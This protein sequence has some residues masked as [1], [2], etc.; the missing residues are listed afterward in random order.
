MKAKTWFNIG[1]TILTF[2]IGLAVLIFL[3][4]QE[5]P[6][7]VENNIVAF[8][9]LPII[10]FVCISLA[11]FTLYS[12]RWQIILNSHLP[13]EK[14]IPLHKMYMHRLAGFA[15]SYLTPAAQVGGEPVRIAMVSTEGVSI[16]AATS[17]VVLDIAFELS[18]YIVFILAGVLLAIWEG[19]GDSNSFLIIGAGLLIL[20]I[21]LVSFFAAMAYGKG[22]FSNIFSL[23]GLRRFKRLQSIDRGI[24]D[25]EHLMAEFLAGKPKR[26]IVVSLLSLAVIS[27]RIIEV[28]YIAYFFGVN[29]DFGSAFLVGT[30]PGIALLL[31]VPAGLGIF[32]GGFSA[33]FSLLG[34]P[35][36]AVAFA[37]IIRIRDAIFISLGVMFILSKGRAFVERRILKRK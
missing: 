9:L 18:A 34:I 4:W 16:R 13:K 23:L 8:G 22:F 24:R 15:M 7:S 27:F 17:S 28:F 26:L 6:E 32:E 11:N 33:V 2:L 31:P 30:L 37:L 14:H 3:I 1:V 29:L 12:L 20:L 5:G 25:S 10:G 35:L 21:S 19:L 36:S